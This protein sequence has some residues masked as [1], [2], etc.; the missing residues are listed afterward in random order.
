MDKIIRETLTH[1]RQYVGWN[2]RGLSYLNAR[3]RTYQSSSS[4][5]VTQTPRHA[6]SENTSEFGHVNGM[7]NSDLF[8]HPLPNHWTIDALYLINDI[9]NWTECGFVCDKPNHVA[10]NDKNKRLYLWCS[11]WDTCRHW[12]LFVGLQLQ[13]CALNGVEM[14]TLVA[15]LNQS[16][17]I[18]GK[19]I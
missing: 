8:W 10:A 3:Q 7:H 12:K 2:D 18:S 13:L 5:S 11:V 14:L 19:I 9:S 4:K 17:M 16:R 1:F 15:L 6:Y